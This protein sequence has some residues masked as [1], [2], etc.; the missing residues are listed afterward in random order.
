[1]VWTMTSKATV[2]EPPSG[3]LL[4][5]G[6]DGKVWTDGLELYGLTARG[7][8]VQGVMPGGPST[9]PTP[10]ELAA[11]QGAAKTAYGPLQPW[12]VVAA[13]FLL[14]LALS[15]LGA[16]FW[17]TLLLG[18]AGAAALVALP[19]SRQSRAFVGLFER[20]EELTLLLSDVPTQAVSNLVDL[21]PDTP[22]QTLDAARQPVAVVVRGLPGAERVKL[23]SAVM[24]RVAV[25]Q[26]LAARKR[27]TP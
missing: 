15:F 19:V 8:T 26:A 16:P 13:L 20:R 18:L 5:S 21:A 25:G 6:P 7:V 17:L 10:A 9:Q 1:M 11:V 24:R 4:Y 27:R 14:L 12:M 23:A 3:K 22:A 2:S